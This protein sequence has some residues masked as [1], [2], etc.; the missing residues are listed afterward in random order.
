MNF[1]FVFLFAALVILC[2]AILYRRKAGFGSGKTISRDNVEL[3]SKRYKLVGRPD[4]IVQRGKN[5]IAEDKKSSMRVYDSHRVQM[6]VYMLLLEEEY[7]K[8][9]P[10]SVLL[11]GNGRREKIKNTNELRQQVLDIIQR[12]RT[13]RKELTKPISVQAV[14]QKCR[15]C[16]QRD[17]CTQRAA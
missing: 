14:P 15:A 1:P 13:A 7:G 4:R 16:A 5:F 3:R 10:Y 17:N 2:L 6:G 12:I 9:P 8:R 11:L